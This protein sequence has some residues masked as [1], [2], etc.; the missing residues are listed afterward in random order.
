V[1]FLLLAIVAVTLAARHPAAAQLLLSPDLRMRAAYIYNLAKFV[2]W[3]PPSDAP[4]DAPIV[5][6]VMGRGALAAALE[7]TVYGKTIQGRPVRVRLVGSV[8]ELKPCHL[9]F[10]GLAGGT[11]DVARAAAQAGVLTV[12]EGEDF[13]RSGGMVN[14]IPYRERVRFQINLSAVESAGLRISS[15]LLRLAPPQARSALANP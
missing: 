9:L 3:P 15:K 13:V 2:E 5:F 12:G 8:L 14:L 7:M 6:G 11:G 1:R 4:S 10:I